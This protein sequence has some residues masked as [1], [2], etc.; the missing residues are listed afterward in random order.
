MREPSCLSLLNVEQVKLKLI[1]QL[2]IPT[3]HTCPWHLTVMSL[4]V[5]SVNIDYDSETGASLRVWDASMAHI[6]DRE[7][8]GL[9]LH[10]QGVN[11]GHR[12]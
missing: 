3:R 11:R 12:S 10:F 4:P 1:E 6:I 8:Q 5:I 7:N 9:S 2:L